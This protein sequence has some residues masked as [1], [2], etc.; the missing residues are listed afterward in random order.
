MENLLSRCRK[1]TGI[2]VKSMAFADEAFLA[3]A[4][5]GTAGTSFEPPDLLFCSHMRAALFDARGSLAEIASP[6]PISVSL[7]DVRPAVGRVFFPL[8][9]RLPVML[10]NTSL[11]DGS[12]D[13]F[14]AL[15]AAAGDDPF[16]GCDCWAELLYTEAAARGIRLTGETERDFVDPQVTALYNK[17]AM[18]VFRGG[19]VS[20]ENP[21]E[22]VRQG[23]LPCAVTMSTAL[24]G[25]SDK[26]LEVRLV[27]LPEGAELR[28]PAELMGFVL[29]DGADTETAAAF[30][31]WLWN[32]AG[33]EAA[34]EACLSPIIRTGV[35]GA[36]TELGRRLNTLT[37][38]VPFFLPEAEEP[39]TKNRAAF[40][41]WLR[42]TLDLLN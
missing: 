4:F 9:S 11:T 25:L 29:F 28:Y 30:F 23:L 18:S 6:L 7:A 3:A 2:Q 34:M 1:E 26:A 35:R 32:G 20:A 13:S 36:G 33:T 22:Y 38:D 8:G 10:V 17:L 39:F 27:P 15:L 21:A 40:E 14:E 16:L 42:E 31:Q 24:A 12:F 37:E 41:D 5:E 19:A